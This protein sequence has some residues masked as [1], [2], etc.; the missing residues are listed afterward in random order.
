MIPGLF[1]AW[2]GHTDESR[3]LAADVTTAIDAAYDKRE[4]AAALMGLHPAD[5]SRQLAGR[6][7]LNLWRLT[8]LS[9]GFWTALL[10][11]RA[12]RLGGELLSSEQLALLKGAA[13][14]GPRML[15]SAMSRERRKAS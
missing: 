5:L 7:P 9:S 3:I 10:A 11:A 13:A 15:R 6:D 8:S 1:A 14:M 12:R 4:T 2:C